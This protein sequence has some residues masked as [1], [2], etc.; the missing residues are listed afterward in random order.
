MGHISSL[1]SHPEYL[2]SE[3]KSSAAKRSGN[4]PSLAISDAYCLGHPGA[5]EDMP[6]VCSEKE[7]YRNKK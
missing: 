5:Q 1:T 2:R 6:I 4:N 3:A 7:N